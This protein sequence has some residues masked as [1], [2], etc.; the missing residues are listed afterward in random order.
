LRAV[1]GS[2]AIARHRAFRERQRAHVV[3]DGTRLLGA[4][5]LQSQI[6]LRISNDCF[7]TNLG[8]GSDCCLWRCDHSPELFPG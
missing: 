2:A 1:T 6:A 5:R 3:A 7:A 8:G 4:V